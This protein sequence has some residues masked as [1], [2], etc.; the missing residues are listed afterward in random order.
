MPLTPEQYYAHVLATADADGRVPLSRMTGWEVFPFEPEGLRVVP[1]QA[2]VLP[3]P[4]RYG[5]GGRACVA[6]EREGGWLWTDNT[7]R[8]RVLEGT[9]APLLLMLEP[10][11]HHDLTDL[12]DE[13]AA[14]LGVLLVHLARAVESLPGIARCHLSRW[15]DG[16]AHLHVFAYARPEGFSQLRGTCMAVWDDLLPPVAPIVRF[17]DSRLVAQALVAS[18]GG[19]VSTD[20]LDW[21][22]HYAFAEQV[23]S[24]D[25]NGALVT[26]VAGLTPG[27]VLDVG[28][29]EG[30]DAVWLAQQGWQVTGLD[31]T[32]VALDRA[33]AAAD[34]AGV[35]VTWVHAGLVEAQLPARSFDLV[36]TMYPAIPSGPAA[37]ALLD[38]VAPGGTLLVVH[39]DVDPE[40]ARAHGFDPGDYV[41]PAD[42]RALLDDDW[43][44]E[45]DTTRERHAPTSGAGAG[46]AHDIVL[47]ARRLR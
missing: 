23:W 8:V 19:E 44:V 1:L 42:V 34:S 3:E 21:D 10:L 32:S 6:C 29:G 25:P 18:Y 2:P 9:G 12:P 22:A 31:V 28:C 27:R 39:H 24:G 17:R 11:A 33:R 40:T 5:E 47:R 26:E 46:H 30:A 37:Q 43:A 35:T 38:V 13:L 4:P 20:D 15:G 36:S 16:G 45:V 41:M 7:W 14:Q